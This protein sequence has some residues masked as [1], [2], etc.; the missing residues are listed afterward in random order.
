MTGVQTCA[1]PI[2]YPKKVGKFDAKRSFDK[3]KIDDELLELILKAV[4]RQSGSDAWRKDGGQ[5][6]PNPSTWLNQGRWED[7]GVSFVSTTSQP[8][9]RDP[10]LVKLDQD[11]QITKPPSLETLQKMAQ[12]RSS[13]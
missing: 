10:A 5:F 7:E 11:K 1:L 9:G 4:A 6:I 13:K 8:A 2:S 3:R 12:L